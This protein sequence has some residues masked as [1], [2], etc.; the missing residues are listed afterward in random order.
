MC[1]A[2][3]GRCINKEGVQASSSSSKSS[4][5]GSRKVSAANTHDMNGARCLWEMRNCVFCCR[6]QYKHT[7]CIEN[8]ESASQEELRDDITRGLYLHSTCQWV[9]KHTPPWM[10][11]GANKKI[12]KTRA[13]FPVPIFRQRAERPFTACVVRFVS[14]KNCGSVGVPAAIAKRILLP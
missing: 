12:N 3:F 7:I 1:A 9:Q 5:A 10:K 2:P 13:C 11:R 8:D 4:Q 6:A 14:I